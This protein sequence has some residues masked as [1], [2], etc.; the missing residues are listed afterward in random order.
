MKTVFLAI[1]L[2]VS[3]PSVT[4]AALRVDQILQEHAQHGYPPAAIGVEHLLQASDRPSDDA[5]LEVRRT[6]Q[7]ELGLYAAAAN[8]MALAQSTLEKLQAMATGENCRSCRDQVLLIQG[9]MAM[10]QQKNPQV[11]EIL[12]RLEGSPSLEPRIALETQLLRAAQAERTG[13]YVPSI[14]AAVKA[15][16]MAAKLD[17]PA[18]QTRALNTQVLA[19]IGRR[20]LDRA[21][22]LAIEGYE[23]ASRINDRLHMVYFRGNQGVVHG[24]RGDEARKY[25]ALQDVLELSR[26]QKGMEGA[27]LATLV[28]LAEYH[29]SRKEYDR[30]LKYSR[31][32]E[33]MALRID[34]PIGRAM[35]MFNT[36]RAL[37]ET[38]NTDA[39]IAHLREAIRLGESTGA[40][41][42]VLDMYQGLAEIYRRADRVGDALDTM[43]RVVGLK[44]EI[45][46]LQRD[47]AVLELQEKY[48]A[49][50]KQREIERLS[51]DNARKQAAVKAGSLEKRLWVLLAVALFMAAVLL[52]QGLRG[53]RRKNIELAEDN[54]SLAEE[55]SVDPLTGAFNR[56]HCQRLMTH[57]EASL[58][59]GR[60]RGQ[61]GLVLLDVDFF[62]TVNDTYGHVAGDAVLV[63]VAQRLKTLVRE[64]DALIRWGGEEFVLMLPGTSAEG[65]AAAAAR[66]LSAIANEPVETDGVRIPITVSAG[67]IAWPMIGGQHW[68]DALHIADLALYLSKSTGRN[69]ATCLMA[70]AEG[71]NVDLIRRDLSAAQAAGDVV[72]HTVPGPNRPLPGEPLPAAAT[73][74]G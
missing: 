69:R 46:Q 30:A 26:D 58:L 47:A 11:M 62:K 20:D 41:G 10:R 23:V 68:E 2:L 21:L 3:A 57:H 51:L 70:V 37:A 72:L 73:S 14:A 42:Y 17:R 4:A 56:R 40:K 35:A 6:Y 15:Q 19:N 67:C 27:E 48:S 52:T 49:E 13:Q 32:A 61:I 45:T 36:A 43:Y 60:S 25:A 38:G 22:K 63:T 54:A 28:N 5:P 55:S 16:E 33:A 12:A 39:G 7:F 18:D 31:Q 53:M 64:K 66:V 24:H 44:D 65:L 50:R 9:Y 29:V 1:L 59:Q 34:E 71:A 74:A 8:K